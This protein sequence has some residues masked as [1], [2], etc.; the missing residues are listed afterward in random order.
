MRL[1]ISCGII[2]FLFTINIDASAANNEIIICRAAQHATHLSASKN[3]RE[4]YQKIGF[5][6]TFLDLPNKRSL[7]ETETGKCDGEVG[8]IRAAGS[9]KNLIQT[10]YPIHQIKAF[11]YSLNSTDNFNKW[12]DLKGKRVA[13]IRGE[14]YAEK[15]LKSYSPQ[16]TN[17]YEELITLLNEKKV[18][19]IIGLEDA[20]ALQ[21]LSSNIQPSKTPLFHILNINK[22]ELLPK[23]NTQLRK[24]NMSQ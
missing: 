12:S 22:V 14:L 3:V 8:R 24:M 10:R 7:F 16:F 21:N 17:S 20:M 9:R 15:N 2:I 11:S 13:A 19:A 4:V 5:N 18:D 23:L 1:L 6:V